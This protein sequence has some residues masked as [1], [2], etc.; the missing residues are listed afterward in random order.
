[1]QCQKLKTYM[2][3]G[4]V[5]FL[6]A[7]AIRPNPAQPRK[8]FSEEQLQQLRDSISQHGILQPLSVRRI[9]SSYELIAGERRLRAAQMAGLTEIPCIVMT[10]D[11]K[12]S[13]LA[14]MVENLQRQDLDFVEEAKGL[15]LL[16]EKWGMSQEQLAKILGMSQSAI[17]NK[18]RLL[19][20][21][22]GVL[23]AILR[24]G[25]VSRRM[26]RSWSERIPWKILGLVASLALFL[27]AAGVLVNL[28]RAA[29]LPEPVVLPTEP[30]EISETQPTPTVSPDVEQYFALT[31]PDAQQE[32]AVRQ[33]LENPDENVYR[34]NLADITSLTF[35]G[36]MVLQDLE[37]AIIAEDGRCLVNGAPVVMGKVEDLSLFSDMIRLETLSLVCQPLGSLAPLNDLVLLKELN[38]AGST[39]ED[40]SELTNLPSLEILHLEHTG[41]RDLTPLN[42]LPNL[43]I[44]TV[45]RDMLPLVWN[46]DADYA[47][48][49]VS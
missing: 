38:L 43:K 7:R 3:T 23:D 27:A 35:C 17:A 40:L 33:V 21:S 29:Q 36:H 8:V 31:F 46:A 34:R 14:A 20:H 11:E 10:M 24:S 41:V 5:V 25:F 9:G 42:D 12:E 37:N 15:S 39:V 26:H 18:L 28:V 44:V 6:P 1:M 2:E 19:R 4:R 49:L 45:N 16:M 30:T 47:V 48:I 32:Q 13:S 22:P